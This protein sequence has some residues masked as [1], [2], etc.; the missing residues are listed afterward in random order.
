MGCYWVKQLCTSSAAE[1]AAGQV[2]YRLIR[3]AISHGCSPSSTSSPSPPGG[4]SGRPLVGENGIL[5]LTQLMARVA[6]MEQAQ[7]H[8]LFGQT[9]HPVSL[10]RR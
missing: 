8:S 1:P 7:G 3:L 5:P 6:E 4:C 10:A 9:A 2:S